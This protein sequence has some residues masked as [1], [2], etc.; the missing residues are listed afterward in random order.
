MF[1]KMMNH[2]WKILSFNNAAV[3]D[4]WKYNIPLGLY[5]LSNLFQFIHHHNKNS[6]Y[7]YM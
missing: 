4:G 6:M 5:K 3:A 1:I 7:I 2:E